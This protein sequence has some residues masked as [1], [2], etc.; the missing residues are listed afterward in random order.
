MKH[1][2]LFT[3]AALLVP[4]RLPLSAQN[5]G[6][7]DALLASGGLPE[8]ESAYYGAARANPHDPEA[9]LALGRY[10]AARGAVRVGAVLLEEARTFGGDPV[11]IGRDLAPL[12][13]DIADYASLAS[14][15]ASPL[16][17][18]E[19]RQASWLATHAPALVAP[20]SVT[21]VDY[22]PSSTPA[23]LGTMTIRIA[24][25]TM[26]A[27]IDARRRGIV[28]ARGTRAASRVMKFAARP[29]GAVPAV[30][31]TVRFGPWALVN[32]PLTIGPTDENTDAV[33]GIDVLGRFAATLD[34]RAARLT[35]RADGSVPPS[36]PGE[37]I[38][39]LV[40]TTDVRLLEGR[41]F[42]PITQPAVA[43]V[44]RT[45]RWTIDAKRG[46]LLIEP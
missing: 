39:T 32:A 27:V 35:V 16:S 9:R 1:I 29:D 21:T 26:N 12:Y 42:V 4:A 24:G 37:R 6:R 45:H 22:R 15:P 30:A 36:T 2:V 38:P 28:I 40:D 20:E 33:I 34:P 10:L 23:N 43:G 3:C 46:S 18:G 17:A 41:R 31:D 44:L 25:Q 14:M 5:V 8:A 11:S 7:A 19:Q 13:R